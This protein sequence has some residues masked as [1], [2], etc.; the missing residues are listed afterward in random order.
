MAGKKDNKQ[1]AKQIKE[2]IGKKRGPR[3]M[4]L[5]SSRDSMGKED[6]RREKRDEYNGFLSCLHTQS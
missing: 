2:K 4:E 3:T 5:V 1:D 6:N